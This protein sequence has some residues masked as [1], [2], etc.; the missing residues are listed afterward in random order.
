MRTGPVSAIGSPGA[1]GPSARAF[2]PVSLRR[3]LMD[4]LS[5]RLIL[6]QALEG[7][8][9]EHAILCPLREGELG[10]KLRPYPAHSLCLG[11]DRRIVEI[12]LWFF[13]CLEPLP[14]IHCRA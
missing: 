13:H 1:V 4:Y 8:M 10:D 12:G 7:W 9:A 11:A 2:S 5:C 14:Y 3:V 6:P